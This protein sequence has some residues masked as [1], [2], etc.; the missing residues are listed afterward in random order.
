MWP[1]LCEGSN[2]TSSHPVAG[3]GGYGFVTSTQPDGQRN[4][5]LLHNS[6]VSEAPIDDKFQH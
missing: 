3:R 1:H 5:A 6:R 2:P 4:Q